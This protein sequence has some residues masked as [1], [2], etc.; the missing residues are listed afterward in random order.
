MFVF[1][2]RAQENENKIIGQRCPEKTPLFDLSLQLVYLDPINPPR[3]EERYDSRNSRRV[4]RVWNY[5]MF[6]LLVN[7]FAIPRSLEFFQQSR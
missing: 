5:G 6:I 3:S 4:R 1:E 2:I 7:S